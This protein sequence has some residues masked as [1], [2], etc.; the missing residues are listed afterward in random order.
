MCARFGIEGIMRTFTGEGSQGM[1]GQGKSSS[2]LPNIACRAGAADEDG[3]NAKSA[4]KGQR[5]RSGA[6]TSC[7]GCSVM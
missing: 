4:V 7:M 5:G 6:K 3:A 2:G 1:A